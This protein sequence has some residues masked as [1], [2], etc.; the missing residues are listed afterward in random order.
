MAVPLHLMVNR[1]LQAD[2]LASVP[3]DATLAFAAR[4]D[5]MQLLAGLRWLEKNATKSALT[6]QIL[7]SLPAQSGDAG[8]P[9][10]AAPADAAKGPNL[11]LDD[12][13][14]KEIAASLGDAWCLYTSPGEGMLVI[15]GVTGTVRVKDHD[16][17][18][19]A[20]E[21]LAAAHQPPAAAPAA[22]KPQQADWAIRKTRFAGH[23]VYYLVRWGEQSACTFTWCLTDTQLVL[24][25]SPQN[26]KAVFAPRGRSTG[27]GPGPGRKRGAGVAARA[28]HAVLRGC[29]GVVPPHLSA[30]AVC[31]QR[32]SG[33]KQLAS[34]RPRSHALARGPHD[35]QVPASG[36]Q[37]ACKPPPR[38]SS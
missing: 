6:E 24:S 30:V 15:T 36:G 5:P 29:G 2:D 10:A 38:A 37:H 11:A 26:I 8:A 32:G 31:G 12:K 14:C 4:V 23:D 18:A 28:D 20:L 35:R 33:A 21:K 13:L 1:P 22:D 25:P 3:R 19:K 16:R 17:L 9:A 7:D 34:G 27:A